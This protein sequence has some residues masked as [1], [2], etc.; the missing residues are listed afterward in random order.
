[1][2]NGQFPMNLYNIL[3][4][5]KK[6]E[7]SIEKIKIKLIVWR[8]LVVH[9]CEEIKHHKAFS[10]GFRVYSLGDDNSNIVNWKAS[11]LK[12]VLSK[13]GK[14]WCRVKGVSANAISFQV[15]R[16]VTSL[17]SPK[18][19]PIIFLCLP[20]KLTRNIFVTASYPGN[21]NSCDGNTNFGSPQ[22]FVSEINSIPERNKV[23]LNLEVIPSMQTIPVVVNNH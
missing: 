7:I 1:M 15:W 17:F 5:I 14:C 18:I 8:F 20:I 11:F 23:P 9:Q 10:I 21:D 16:R 6:Y 3:C 13:I 12:Q 19:N 22:N 2:D 4:V